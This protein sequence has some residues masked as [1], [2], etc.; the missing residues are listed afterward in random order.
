MIGGAA[1]FMVFA[2][3]LAESIA[4]HKRFR[5][6]FSLGLFFTLITLLTVACVIMRAFGTIG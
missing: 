3:I 2:A 4:Q 5:I 1:T 6:Q